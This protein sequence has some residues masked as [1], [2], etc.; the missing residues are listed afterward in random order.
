MEEVLSSRGGTRGAS[1]S[2][3]VLWQVERKAR[4]GYN[5]PDPQLKSTCATC[6]MANLDIAMTRN[7]FILNHKCSQLSVSA[8][9]SFMESIKC[10][11]KMTG[12]KF[13]CFKKQNFNFL[14]AGNYLHGI[15]IGLGTI[16]DLEMIYLEVIYTVRW[17]QVVYKY[18]AQ[19]LV[20]MGV[21]EPKLRLL[22]DDCITSFEE[23]PSSSPP[24]GVRIV[25]PLQ[26][27][28]HC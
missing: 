13:H 21:L 23:A 10:G 4:R 25:S 22:R 12:E 14:C 11:S 17:M 18:C 19:I 7:G 24:L 20:S 27:Y 26:A 28:L 16:S 3:S 9:S 2:W 6:S 5:F 8:G 15:Y 1:S